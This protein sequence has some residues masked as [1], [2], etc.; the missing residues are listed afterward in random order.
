LYLHIILLNYPKILKLKKLKN[1]YILAPHDDTHDNKS[2]DKYF[3]E[4]NELH[5]KQKEA[6]GHNFKFN[7]LLY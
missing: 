1:Y 2:V 4:L 5:Y 7:K 6:V 3:S